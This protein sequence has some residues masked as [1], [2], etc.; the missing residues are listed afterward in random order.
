[1]T[2]DHKKRLAYTGNSVGL[3]GVHC[4][5]YD[6]FRGAGEL[7]VHDH[8]GYELCYLMSGRVRWIFEDAPL[9]ASGLDLTVAPPG[10]VHGGLDDVMHPC[11]IFWIILDRSLDGLTLTGPEKTACR[12]A[13]RRARKTTAKTRE[14]ERALII[15]RD[16]LGDPS[17]TLAARSAVLYALSLFRREFSVAEASPRNCPPPVSTAT[18]IIRKHL[19]EKLS[20]ADIADAVELSPSRLTELFRVHLGMSPGEY[21]VERRIDAARER[22]LKSKDSVTT[23]AYALGFSSSQHFAAAFKQHTGLTPSAWRKRTASR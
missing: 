22:L 20:V 14:L 7:P 5:G 2:V 6:V 4:F 3:P 19:S 12:A 8:N 11:K 17:E 23:I 15:A 21:V 18:A 16:A 13:W 9:E 1:M 10:V